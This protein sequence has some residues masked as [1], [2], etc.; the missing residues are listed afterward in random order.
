VWNVI[1]VLKASI[2]MTSFVFSYFESLIA[3]ASGIRY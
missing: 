2:Y 3:L 1:S